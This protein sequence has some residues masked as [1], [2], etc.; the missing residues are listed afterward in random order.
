MQTLTLESYGVESIIEQNLLS[1]DG[2]HEGTAYE[3][4]HAVGQTL[5]VLGVIC[6]ITGRTLFGGHSS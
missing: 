1:I 5:L 4:G 3:I 2:G 6:S